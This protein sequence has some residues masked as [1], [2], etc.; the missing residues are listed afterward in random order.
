MSKKE[1]KRNKFPHIAELCAFK[2]VKRLFFK[3]AENY[4]S[5]C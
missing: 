4:V 3:D 2:L 1:S 5:M